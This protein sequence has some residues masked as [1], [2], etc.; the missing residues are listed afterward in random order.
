[1]KILYT[2]LM[3][4]PS[5]GPADR[6]RIDIGS[7]HADDRAFRRDAGWA[8]L[9]SLEEGIG[10]TLDGIGVGNVGR[11]DNCGAAFLHDLARCRLEALDAAR[12]QSDIGAAPAESA[13]R[14]ASK[15]A[16]RSGNDDGFRS[17]FARHVRSAPDRSARGRF[18]GPC[19][20][21]DAPAIPALPAVARDAAGG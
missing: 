2:P 10:R 4:V 8:P 19:A 11:Q 3:I 13:C 18:P 16:R 5:V 9:V 20:C 7:Y 6:A 17:V 21:A 14:G 12:Q 1:M 15:T